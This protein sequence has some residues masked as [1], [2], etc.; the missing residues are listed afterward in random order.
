[1]VSMHVWLDADVVTAGA[2]LLREGILHQSGSAVR[3]TLS[4]THN[5]AGSRV[6]G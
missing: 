3:Y 6:T 2:V 4:L 5:Q 1:M